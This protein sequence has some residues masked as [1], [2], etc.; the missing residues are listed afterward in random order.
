M[1]RALRPLAG[2]AVAAAALAWSLPS[3]PLHID[4]ATPEQHHAYRLGP[5]TDPAALHYTAMA[6]R[7]KALYPASEDHGPEIV[8]VVHEESRRHRLDPCLVMGVIARES[9]FRPAA[10]NRRD[11]GLMQVNVDWHPELVARAGGRQALLD[12][13]RNVR[14]GTELLAHYRSRS[15]SDHEALQR[16]HGLGKRSGYVQWVQAESRRLHAA[17][18]CDT[19]ALLASR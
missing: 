9:S 2:G 17:G 16:Y 12:P 10:R 7:L 13:V 1:R 19:D 6:G 8:R 5:H 18:T 3:D 15:R 11:T 4:P 14:A